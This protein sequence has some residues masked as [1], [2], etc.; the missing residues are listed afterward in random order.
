L[1]GH[2]ELLQDLHEAGYRRTPQREIILEVIHSLGS[3]FSAEQV[4][5]AVRTKS[6]YINR[7]TV[8]RTL[9]LFRDIGL[10]LELRTSNGQTEYELASAGYHHHLICKS[11]GRMIE[12]ADQYLASLEKDLLI[13]YGFE[14]QIQHL[15]IFGRCA[16]CRQSPATRVPESRG[17]THHISPRR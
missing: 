1:P 11:C 16:D 15:A 14:A 4:C 3:H 9:D 13:D 6:S 12:L 2:Q 5:R 10:L 8:Y 7:S 17:A